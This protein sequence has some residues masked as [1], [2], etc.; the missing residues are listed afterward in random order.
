[1]VDFITYLHSIEISINHFGDD[2]TIKNIGVKKEED[3]IIF[4]VLL[5]D[6]TPKS[7]KE[8]F[9]K[10]ERLIKA[11]VTKVQ[12]KTR[13]TTDYPADLHALLEKLN[14]LRY[15]FFFQC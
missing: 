5:R 6:A 3:H 11:V 1:M 12:P 13:Y 8:D 15:F 4:L 7:K 9:K 10:L 14:N 2:L